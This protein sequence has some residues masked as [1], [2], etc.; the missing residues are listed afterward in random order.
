MGKKHLVAALGAAGLI[1]AAA[2]AAASFHL[3][4]IVQVYGGAASHPDA[5]YVVLQMCS[6][7][8][9]L[10]GGRSVA[11]YDAAGSLFHSATFPASVGSGTTQSKIFVGTSSAKT[12]F[13]L[14]T[15]LAM[16]ADILPAGGKLC[17]APDFGPVDCIG[18]GS[19]ATPDVTIGTPFD[20]G[21]GLPTGEALQRDLS[22]DG[23]ATI[24][25]CAGIDFDDTDDSLADFDPAAPTPGNN[26]GVAG[27]LNVDHVFLHG[28]E[29]GA[30]AGWSAV[31]P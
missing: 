25:D 6:G 17:F 13:G 18:W 20:A 24:L 19:I 3:M 28:F 7:G 8:Q 26:A 27:V 29:A 11:F 16:R 14:S 21:V 30:S 9:N 1:L 31:V 12:L 22:I 5:Q 23:G 10:V 4:R 15:D 2:P